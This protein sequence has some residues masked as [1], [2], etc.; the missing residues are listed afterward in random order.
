MGSIRGVG[1]GEGKGRVGRIEVVGEG[2]GNARLGVFTEETNGNVE[3]S[4]G[5]GREGQA[6]GCW[7]MVGRGRQ[8]VVHGISRQSRVS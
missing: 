2:D 5:D 8:Q 3:G 6:A 1:S 4:L 7:V